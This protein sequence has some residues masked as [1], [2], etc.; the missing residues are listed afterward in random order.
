MGGFITIQIRRG[1]FADLPASAA[2][3]EFLWC[4][5]TGQIFVGNGPDLELTPFTV[6]PGGA[7]GAIQFNSAASFGGAGGLSWDDVNKILGLNAGALNGGFQV[8]FANGVVE[9]YFDGT[10]FVLDMQ[11][12]E[13]NV[14]FSVNENGFSV[15]DQT[16]PLN[17]GNYSLKLI[18]GHNPAVL[19][20]AGMVLGANGMVGTV[21]GNELRVNANGIGFNTVPGP[22]PVVTGSRG[23][24]AALASLL[25]QLSAIGLITD[26]TTP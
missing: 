14:N 4:T 6:H 24:N 12:G 9:L 23:G 1:L 26:D 10:G 22:F 18:S 5:D 2:L 13:S 15:N 20:G 8:Q 17:P 11:I 16:D 7:P 25:T 19:A 21:P 3:G